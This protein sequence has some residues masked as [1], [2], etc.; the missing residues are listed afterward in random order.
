ML[1]HTKQ[2]LVL[3]LI[4]LQMA[5]PFI[6]AHAFE[7]DNFK[8]HILH[9]HAAE[10]SP[11][12]TS[13]DL[14]QQEHLSQQARLAQH[15]ADTIFTVDNGIKNTSADYLALLAIFLTF[16]LLIFN[17]SSRFIRQYAQTPPYRQQY[18]SLQNPRA[19]PF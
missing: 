2:F 10:I 8:A 11:T 9:I 16:C 12:S 17:S 15:Q 19:P 14:T 5:A 13:G 3:C 18:Y 1:K 4:A 6:H 7:L